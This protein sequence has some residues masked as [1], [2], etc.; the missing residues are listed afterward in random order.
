LHPHRRG[1]HVARSLVAWAGLP[2]R[3]VALALF[4]LALA[5]CASGLAAQSGRRAAVAVRP[6]DRA[7]LAAPSKPDCSFQEI[8][9]GDTVPDAAEAARRKL[10]FERECYRR[11]EMQ[12]RA[13]LRR[14]QAAVVAGVKPAASAHCGF[15]W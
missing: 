4:A 6:P 7:L 2:S 1:C 13:R 15:S 8:G 3:F 12:M 14:L 5:G 10:D 9:L 11:A